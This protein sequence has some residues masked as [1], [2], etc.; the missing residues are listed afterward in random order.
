LSEILLAEE[1]QKR[2]GT[3]Q[4]LAGLD[5]DIGPGQVVGLVGPNGS[6][7]TTFIRIVVGFLRCDSGRIRVL[8]R[9]P[10]QDRSVMANIGIV[11]ERTSFPVRFRVIDYLERACR[12]RN[13]PESRAREVLEEWDLKGALTKTIGTLSAGMMQRLALSHAFL[14][15]PDFIVADEPT[16][17]LDPFG[18]I[19]ILAKIAEQHDDRGRTF[20]MTSHILGDLDKVCSSIAFLKE[21]RLVAYGEPEKLLGPAVRLRFRIS[22]DD[23]VRL[24]DELSVLPYHFVFDVEPRRLVVDIPDD[25]Q[26]NFLGLIQDVATGA[27]IRIFS[28]EQ[29]GTTLEEVFLRIIA[30]SPTR[31]ERE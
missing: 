10:W 14:H 30:D 5:L 8:D 13:L 21:G 12:I 24:R 17:N 19:G 28:V 27:G 6:G 22:C 20:L 7:K 23:M 9:D 16:S 25:V 18:R 26:L 31:S 1:I 15:D 11:P 2:F 4:A 3:T 29:V